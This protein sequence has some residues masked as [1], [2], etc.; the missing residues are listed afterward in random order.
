MTIE[1]IEAAETTKS[2]E[3]TA[4]NPTEALYGFWDWIAQSKAKFWIGGGV[5][6]RQLHSALA[7]F[8]K[9]NVLPPLTGD[10]P[11]HVKLPQS[12]D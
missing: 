5:H 7:Q 10:W 11:D 9:E 8:C 3:T 6:G 2:T 1:T 4:M 12:Y